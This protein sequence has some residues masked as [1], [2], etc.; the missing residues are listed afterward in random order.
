MRNEVITYS[1]N[2]TNE[3]ELYI[4]VQNGEVLVRAPWYVTKNK[5]QEAVNEKKKWI[6]KKLKEYQINEEN[7]MS[8]RPIQILGIIYN[9][10]VSYK[11]ISVIEC[12]MENNIIKVN[13]PKKY[14]KIDNESMTDILIDKMYF[15]IAERE[16]ECI[17]EKTRLTLGFAPED[18]EIMEMN[19]CLAKCTLDKKIIINPR[20]IKYKRE[21]I[22]YIILHEFCHLK[23]KN[24]T[25]SFYNM[26]ERY[27]PEYKNYE[28]KNI[29]Y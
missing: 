23:Y 1:V 9:L 28:I 11:N 4:S 2:K 21:V 26:V 19:D 13:L 24:H 16:L 20:I 17:M 18:Y 6:M 7:E 5:I 25:K 10:K 22:E 3:K 14:K 27:M 12:N 29:K 8:L 15:K